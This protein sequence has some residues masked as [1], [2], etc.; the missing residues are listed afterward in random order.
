MSHLLFLLLERRSR[1]LIRLPVRS[2]PIAQAAMECE[3]LPPGQGRAWST[4]QISRR[5]ARG[6]NRLHPSRTP[7]GFG[8]IP[9]W[10]SGGD[11]RQDCDAEHA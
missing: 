9:G 2:Y 7:R 1:H 10:N 3:G 8:A 5:R 6:H 11:P 4:L